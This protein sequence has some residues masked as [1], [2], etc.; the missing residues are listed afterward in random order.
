MEQ[1]SGKFQKASGSG[2]FQKVSVIVQK[3][4]GMY[5]YTLGNIQ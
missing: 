3:V 2:K 5:Q 1:T 4:T